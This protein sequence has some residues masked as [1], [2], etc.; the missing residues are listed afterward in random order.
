MMQILTLI[1]ILIQ[2]FIVLTGLPEKLATNGPLLHNGHNEE[3]LVVLGV[4]DD[5]N[6]IDHIGMVELLHD[7][8]LLLQQV[9]HRLDPTQHLLLQF[10]LVHYLDRKRLL[11]VLVNGQLHLPETAL[12]QLRQDQILV[13]LFVPLFVHRLVQ[14][15]RVYTDAVLLLLHQGGL[16]PLQGLVFWAVQRAIWL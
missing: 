14:N 12:P 15:R 7:G 2:F 5:L 9:V 1:L 4:V 8:D 13:D 16:H 6:E 11:G 3:E 10:L